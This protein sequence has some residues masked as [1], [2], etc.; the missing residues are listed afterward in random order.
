[1]ADK[2][3]RQKELDE[4]RK[5]SEADTKAQLE[6]VANARPT[7]TQEENDRA[8]LGY[9]D[10][11]EA[12]DDKESDGS[13]EERSVSAADAGATAGARNRSVSTK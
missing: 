7:P 6:R 13:A 1:M 5:Q 4:Q 3:A 9:Y 8:K 2:D 10:S 12:L 11:V